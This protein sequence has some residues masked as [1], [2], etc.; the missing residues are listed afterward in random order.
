MSIDIYREIIDYL[1]EIVD[2]P[3]DC[4]CIRRCK[5][6]DEYL[7]EDCILECGVVDEKEL[8]KLIEEW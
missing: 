1:C 6:L 5:D 2:D 7:V 8:E 4:Y 3:E